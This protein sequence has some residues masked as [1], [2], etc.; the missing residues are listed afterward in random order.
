[1]RDKVEKGS[2]RAGSSRRNEG[3]GRNGSAVGRKISNR[4]IP[5]KQGVEG[6]GVGE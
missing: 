2:A 5:E 6:L 1:M 4:S 3:L